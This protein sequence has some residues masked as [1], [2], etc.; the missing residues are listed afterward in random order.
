MQLMKGGMKEGMNGGTGNCEICG[1]EKQT[2]GAIRYG[3]I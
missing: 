2:A 3:C 1:G